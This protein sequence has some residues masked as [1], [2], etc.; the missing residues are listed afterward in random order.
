MNLQEVNC[1][2]VTA[3][4]EDGCATVTSHLS[5]GAKS[6]SP[7]MHL[8]VTY[9]IGEGTG[10]EIDTKATVRKDLVYL[11]RFGFKFTMPEGAE[12]LRYFGYGPHEAYEDK[13]LSTTIGMYRTTVTDNFEH[14]VRPQENSAHYGCKWADVTLSAG[15]GLYFAA[16]SFSLS[17]SSEKITLTPV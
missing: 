5:L 17:S 7:T 16:D 13:R 9:R 6:L 11:P 15:Q 4:A 10:I 12:D 14:Y 1:Y 8:T 2:S 3:K